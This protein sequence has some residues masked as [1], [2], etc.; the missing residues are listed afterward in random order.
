M[1]E[2]R[3]QIVEVTDENIGQLFRGNMAV[4]EGLPEDAELVRTWDEPARQTYCFMFES[5]E[6]PTVEQGEK[7]PEADIAVAQRRINVSDY[8]VCP[9]CFET[10]ENGDVRCGQE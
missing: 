8:W 5:E 4:I 6:F 3:V 10:L 2:K 1:T 9:N 7:T